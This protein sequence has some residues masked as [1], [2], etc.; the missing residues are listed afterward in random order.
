MNPLI[1]PKLVEVVECHACECYLCRSIEKAK[2]DPKLTTAGV[3]VRCLIGPTIH[4]CQDCA[5]MLP[6]LVALIEAR[7]AEEYVRVHH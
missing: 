7:S 2:A 6:K 4:L 1:V 5:Q 3:L